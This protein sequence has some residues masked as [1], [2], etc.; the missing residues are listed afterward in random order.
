V[1][2]RE[3]SSRPPLLPA[4]AG[5]T[6]EHWQALSPVKVL[7]DELHRIIVSYLAQKTVRFKHIFLSF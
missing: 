3:V 7:Y 2:E 6:S 4:A 5:G 1:P